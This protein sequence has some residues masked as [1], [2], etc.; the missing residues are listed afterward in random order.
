MVVE[1]EMLMLVVEEELVVVGG[2]EMLMVEM[3]MVEVEML[4]VGE[5]AEVKLV[6]VEVDGM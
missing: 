5:V 3:V 6:I 1:L 2:L 4:V